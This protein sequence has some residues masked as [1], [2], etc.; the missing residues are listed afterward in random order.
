M[1][2]FC[3]Q[4]ES[5]WSAIL[6]SNP[7]LK[8]IVTACERYIPFV[9]IILVKSLFDHGTGILVCCGLVLTFLHANSVLKQ[10]VGAVPHCR[11]EMVTLLWQVARQARRNLGALLA[12]SINLVACVLFIYFVFLD[13]NLPLR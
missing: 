11:E 6:N 13:N 8:A 5:G 2:C 4:P 1:K 3:F 10:Q 9:L 7:E 12:I